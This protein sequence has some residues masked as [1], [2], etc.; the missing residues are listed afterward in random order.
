MLNHSVCPTLCSPVDCSPPG[1]SVP[2]ILQARILEAIFLLQG[3]FPARRLDPGLQHCRQMLYC[4]SRQG[5]YSTGELFH[6]LCLFFMYYSCEKHYN[7]IYNIINVLQ[8]CIADCASWAPRL[9]WIYKQTG[10]AKVLLE[11]G[12]FTGR[13]FSVKTYSLRPHGLQHARLPCPSP[14]PRVCSNSC[15]SSR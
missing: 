5:L 7:C 15:P 11:Q 4:L 14:S 6:F 8:D 2:G 12:F 3:I 10:L 1:S 9:C 13:L